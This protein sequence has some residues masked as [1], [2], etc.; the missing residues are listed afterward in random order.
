MCRGVLSFN[1]SGKWAPQSPDCRVLKSISRLPPAVTNARLA[2]ATRAAGRLHLA[3]PRP[4]RIAH[5]AFVTNGICSA[6]HGRRASVCGRRRAFCCGSVSLCAP[7]RLRFTGAVPDRR[8][9]PQ[10]GLS[11]PRSRP[12][13]MRL[14]LAAK[15]AQRV[16]SGPLKRHLPNGLRYQLAPTEYPRM[17]PLKPPP[18]IGVLQ[19]RRHCNVLTTNTPLL[20][21]AIRLRPNVWEKIRH[22][23]GQTN[24]KWASSRDSLGG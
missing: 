23:Q 2:S 15:L 20:T 13:S 1:R 10:S 7:L 11:P 12:Y 21:R 17:L 3:R 8:P 16:L 4:F 22:A 19:R 18:R 24:G 5:R 9:K 14:T 6:P